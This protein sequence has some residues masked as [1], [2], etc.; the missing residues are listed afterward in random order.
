MQEIVKA[1]TGARQEKKDMSMAHDEMVTVKGKVWVPEKVTSLQMNLLIISL[2]KC[3]AAGHRG[4]ES[5]VVYTLQALG[6]Y[7]P[8]Y[9]T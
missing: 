6:P 3:S 8:L 9:S 1:Q 2:A 7:T 4:Q 5:V